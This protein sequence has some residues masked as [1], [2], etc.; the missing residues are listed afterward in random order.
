MSSWFREYTWKSLQPAVAVLHILSLVTLVKPFYG[1]IL[2]ISRIIAYRDKITS[3]ID[4]Y[5]DIGFPLSHSS[6]S[7]SESL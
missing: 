4:I 3:I 1:I 7:Y 2:I 6:N 5:R